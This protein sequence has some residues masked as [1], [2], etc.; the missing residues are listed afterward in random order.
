MCFLLMIWVGCG[1][2]SCCLHSKVQVDRADSM[3]N[4]TGFVTERRECDPW[5][6]KFSAYNWS[7]PH[8]SIFLWL[9]QVIWLLL[10]SVVS[11][12]I[13]L[14]QE[15][16][17]QVTWPSL[18]SVRQGFVSLSP[19]RGG[20]E[21]SHLPQGHLHATNVPHLSH[22]KLHFIWTCCVPFKY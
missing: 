6:Y 16:A 21:Q 2:V 11:W 1:A 15:W 7:T 17:F 3:W 13:I 22:G 19:M 14:R 8:L 4:V 20:S 12:Y 9:K 18:M 10:I 5:D